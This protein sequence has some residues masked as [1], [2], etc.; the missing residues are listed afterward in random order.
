[1]EGWIDGAFW[2]VESATARSTDVL[3]N[4]IPMARL[5]AKRGKQQQLEVPRKRLTRHTLIVYT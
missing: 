4:R 2:V 3:N 1:V 5:S